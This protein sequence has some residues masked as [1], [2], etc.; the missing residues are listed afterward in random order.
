VAVPLLN[1]VSDRTGF[2]FGFGFVD[3]AAERRAEREVVFGQ[4]AQ[5]AH[6]GG[7]RGLGGQHLGQD[8]AQPG[9][10]GEL[11]RE[12]LQTFQAVGGHLA[13]RFLVFRICT[14][15]EAQRQLLGS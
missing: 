12:V 4:L 6:Q 7:A 9:L 1:R 5:A 2:P 13:P 3:Q 15:R 14:S 11:V 10:A 8:F